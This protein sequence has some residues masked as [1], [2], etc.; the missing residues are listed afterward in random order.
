MRILLGVPEF[1]P[2][3]IGWWGAVFEAL[4]HEYVKLWHEVMVVYG[5]YDTRTWFEKIKEYFKDGIYFVQV[6]LIP[7]PGFLPFLKTVL[8]TLPYH[9]GK[10][11]NIIKIF[12]PDIS[13]LHWYGLL[14]INQLAKILVSNNFPYIYTLHGAPVSA[15]KKWW[16]IKMVYNFYKKT[17]GKS[18]LEN[19]CDITAVSQ[20]TIDNFSE[21]LPYRDKIR[22]VHNWIYPEEFEKRVWFNIYDRFNLSKDATIYLSIGRIEWL[23]GFDQFIKMI[24]LLVKSWVDARYFIAGRDNGFKEELDKLIRELGVEDRVFYLWFI[25]WDEK[26]SAL[27]NGN[28]L[29]VPSYTESFGITVLEA[30]ASWLLPV[31]N[32]VWGLKELI[33]DNRNGRS[34]DFSNVNNYVYLMNCSIP[35]QSLQND[36]QQYNWEKIAIA[37]LS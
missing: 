27:Q 33:K 6:P 32:S 18:I 22:V 15:D 29:V 36:I 35:K 8:P 7:T 24:P 3:H 26:L 14:F 23:K 19:A 10:I 21:F 17:R 37:Y 5:N 9:L 28:Y 20:Y 31:V 30:L 2:H 16:I 34:I 11:K 1:P 25:S 4:A 13:H 12:A